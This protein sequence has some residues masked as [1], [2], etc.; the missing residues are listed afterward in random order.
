MLGDPEARAFGE[1]F[2]R[3]E[4]GGGARGGVAVIVGAVAG[5]LE[6][7]GEGVGGDDC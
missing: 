6:A 3:G 7:A 4:L 5:D 2:D 1:R